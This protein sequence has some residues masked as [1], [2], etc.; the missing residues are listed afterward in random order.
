MAP[1]TH[2]AVLALWIAA[3]GTGLA[4][5]HEETQFLAGA[6]TVD[7]TPREPLPMWGY[8]ETETAVQSRAAVLFRLLQRI[9]PVL[10]ND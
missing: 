7:V 1:Q 4:S 8:G 2:F 10:P 9:S 5:G 3:A 6:A